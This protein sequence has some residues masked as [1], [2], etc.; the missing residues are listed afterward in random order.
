MIELRDLFNEEISLDS[1][2]NFQYGLKELNDGT[3]IKLG[4]Y[5]DT[6][7]GRCGMFCPWEWC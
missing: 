6:G 7:T 2:F 4:R 1:L 5:N 3:I